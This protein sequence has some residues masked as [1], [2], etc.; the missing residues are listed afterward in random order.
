MRKLFAK[1]RRG[2]HNEQVNTPPDPRHKISPSQGETILQAL[3]DRGAYKDCSRCGNERHSLEPSL[4]HVYL[5]DATN[6]SVLGGPFI[7]TAIIVCLNCGLVSEHA[8]GA[9]GLLDH[10]A[11]NLRRDAD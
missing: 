4:S 10:P 6:K 9:L 11:F 2:D 8:L 7:P 1:A 3:D 5:F